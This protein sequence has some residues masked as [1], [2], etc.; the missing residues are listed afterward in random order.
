MKGTSDHEKRITD[1]ELKISLLYSKLLIDEDKFD[2]MNQ[3]D[4]HKEVNKQIETRKEESGSM[5]G[6]SC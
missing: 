6:C 4:K 5:Q 2:Q 1:N 3:E